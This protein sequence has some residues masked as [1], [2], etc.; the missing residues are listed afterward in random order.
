MDNTR[1]VLSV[2]NTITGIF[3][4]VEVTKEIYDTYRRFDYNTDYRERKAR[5][6]ET[7]FSYLV[8]GENG[9]I[10]NFH[11]CRIDDEDPQLILDK[12]ESIKEVNNA[13]GLLTDE[14]VRLLLTFFFSGKSE[15]K[16]AAEHGISRKTFRYRKEKTLKKLRQILLEK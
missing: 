3:D 13:I 4:D 2:Y 8:G 12:T 14:E 7:L 6:N 1:Y 11:E 9:G 16:F 5:R 10:E 15:R